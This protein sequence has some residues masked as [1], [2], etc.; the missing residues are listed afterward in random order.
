MNLVVQKYGGAAVS[1]PEH[2]KSVA[3]RILKDHNTGKIRLVVVV[4]A[5]AGETNRLIAL[6]KQVANKP[7]SRESD[8]LVSTGEQITSSLLAIALQEMGHKAIS[9]QGHQVQILTSDLF[10]KAKIKSIDVSKINDHLNKDYIVVVAGFQGVDKDGNITT[11]GRGGSDITAVALASALCADRVEFYKDVDGVFTADPDVCPNARLIKKIG[12][13]EMLELSHHGAK[14]LHPR[15]VELARQKS[16][17]LIV[18]SCLHEKEGSEITREDKIMEQAVVTGIVTDRDQIKISLMNIPDV[19]GILARIFSI[20]AS[21]EINIDM[22]VQ[23]TMGGDKLT[24][25]SFTLSKQDL[26]QAKNVLSEIIDE[27][28]G[29]E[30]QINE[31]MTKVS[32]IGAGMRTHS[33]IAAKMFAALANEGINIYMVNTSEIKISCLV[34]SKYAELSVR[35]LHDVFELA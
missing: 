22:I 3:K 15:A 17:P 32:I 27:F 23:N 1:T 8:V 24:E 26:P 30:H 7:S 20:I 29:G 9:F 12:F 35:I 4:S 18:R 5:M 13:E 19:P 28:P 10:S 34:E 21:H 2:I 25:L 6:S 14:V 11:L 31:N 33:G 16:I